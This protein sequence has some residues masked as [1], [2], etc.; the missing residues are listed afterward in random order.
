MLQRLSE[1]L[2]DWWSAAT[3]SA[4]STSTTV[5]T[6][7]AQLSD[8]DDF[9]LNWYIRN[10]ALDESRPITG[11]AASTNT[12]THAAFTTAVGNANTYELHR[13]DPTLKHLALNRA[14]EEVFPFLYLP[15]RDETLVVDDLL[16]DT[17]YE[18]AISGGAFPDWTNSGSPT[19]TAQTGIKFHGAQSARIVAA[20][21]AAGQMYQEPT[22]NI[23]EITNKTCR[24]ARWVYA[25][26]ADTARVR[27]DWDGTNFANSSYHTSQDRW[28]RLEVQAAVPTTA[29]RVRAICEV[30]AS[31]TGYFDAGGD[32]GLFIDRIKRYT[33]PTT[34]RLWPAY[35]GQQNNLDEPDGSYYP[36]RANLD[37]VRGAHLRFEGKG[38]L[39]RPTTDAGTTEIAAPQVNLVYAYAAMYLYRA[40]ASAMFSGT[41]TRQGYQAE[42]QNWAQEASRIA[43]QK[44]IA[45]PKLGAAIGK[46]IYHFEEDS[47]GRYL[48]LDR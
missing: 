40:L 3:T 9:C 37:V 18:K 34:L 11:Y 21:G 31:G 30:A 46:G 15:I 4:G 7:L 44:G 23:K 25:T 5:D 22:I 48:V 45:M 32:A 2:N 6:K 8:Q 33:I 20:A 27:L 13:I 14:L 41:L 24:F 19:V 42:A 38:L 35:V 12:I 47:S 28:E 39:T 43:A 17:S 29:T 26:A 1:M 10:V 36:L 16:T